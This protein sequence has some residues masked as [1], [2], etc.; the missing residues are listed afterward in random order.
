[1]VFAGGGLMGN[2]WL[3]RS[4][5]ALR[6]GNAAQ[7][8]S[9]AGRANSWMPWSSEPLAQRARAQ[10][11]AGQPAAAVQS[12]DAALDR[13]PDDWSL[14]LLKSRVTPG[15][16]EPMPPE[17]MLSSSN[18]HSYNFLILREQIDKRVVD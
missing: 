14:W 2:I 3:D 16:R 13:S 7:A 17:P 9:D 12:I 6:A 11:I 15:R 1:M 10:V 18:R 8:V 5:A 4:Y